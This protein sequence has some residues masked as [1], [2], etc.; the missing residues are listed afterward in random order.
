MNIHFTFHHQFELTADGRKCLRHRTRILARL[1]SLLLITSAAYPFANPLNMVD[2][3]SCGFCVISATRCSCGMQCLGMWK[4]TFEF[5]K[6]FSCS[7]ELCG[8]V[9]VV[10]SPERVSL[11]STRGGYLRCSHGY[12]DLA[13]SHTLRRESARAMLCMAHTAPAGENANATL[14]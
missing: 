10:E 13:N 2:F 9:P 5:T 4:E 6:P 8:L 12:S 14:L 11:S 3:R 7:C 1:G